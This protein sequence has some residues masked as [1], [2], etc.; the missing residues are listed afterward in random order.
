MILRE[1]NGK[2][3]GG[4]AGEGATCIKK[5]PSNRFPISQPRRMHSYRLRTIFYCGTPPSFLLVYRTRPHIRSEQPVD[6]G[7]VIVSCTSAHHYQLV[8]DLFLIKLS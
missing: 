3:S 4:G 8:L 1:I 6:V 2:D 5:L 7:T